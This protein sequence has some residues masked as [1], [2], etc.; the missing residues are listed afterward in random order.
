MCVFV[1]MCVCVLGR[2]LA[3]VIGGTVYRLW[4]IAHVR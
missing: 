3:V 1:C 4:G 2:W